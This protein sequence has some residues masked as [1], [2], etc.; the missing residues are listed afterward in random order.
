MQ[1]QGRE[2]PCLTSLLEPLPPL[3]VPPLPG[4]VRCSSGD[5]TAGGLVA[6]V[7]LGGGGIFGQ[8]VGVG[9]AAAGAGPGGGRESHIV[10][11]QII[12]T[13][14]IVDQLASWRMSSP[15]RGIRQ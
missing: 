3:A 11:K 5:A 15:L 10:V 14:T 12:G 8:A 1:H 2:P 13:T 7:V 6:A 4:P 9:A